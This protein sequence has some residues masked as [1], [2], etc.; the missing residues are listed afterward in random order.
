M[1][2]RY[3][4]GLLIFILTFCMVS[5]SGYRD[6]EIA[7][8]AYSRMLTILIGCCFTVFVCVFVCPVW[9][10]TDLHH[11]VANNIESLATFFHGTNQI[12]FGRFH[13]RIYWLFDLVDRFVSESLAGFGAEYFGLLQEQG[14]V[15]KVD[16]QKY[17]TILNS[18]SN[19]ESLVSV[20]S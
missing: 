6:D 20:L 14:E 7:K 9:A 8:L 1:K 11:L 5:L 16:M 10:G 13:E 15:G 2:A 3:D 12:M 19:E 17:R 18:K 4:Y